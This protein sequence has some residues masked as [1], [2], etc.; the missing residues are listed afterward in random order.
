MVSEAEQ[1]LFVMNARRKDLHNAAQMENYLVY[2]DY[3]LNE[4]QQMMHMKPERALRQKEPVLGRYKRTME[5]FPR[6]SLLMERYGR[7]ISRLYQVV[8]MHRNS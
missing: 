6:L 1:M 8:L 4:I 2:T 7:R 3:I 5:D